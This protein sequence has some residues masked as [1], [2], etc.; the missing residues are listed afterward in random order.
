MEV[1]GYRDALEV[2]N[3]KF[4]D[5]VAISANEAAGVLG[6]S[7]KTVLKHIGKE[8]NPLPHIPGDGRS[9]LIPLPAFAKWLAGAERKL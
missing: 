7:Y 5:R 2:L 8:K 3:A 1:K 6:I 9:F 4:P